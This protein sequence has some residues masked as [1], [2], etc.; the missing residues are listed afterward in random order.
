MG[1]WI[2]HCNLQSDMLYNTM[3]SPNIWSYR[4]SF[5]F[6][7]CNS[8]S[9]GLP[10]LRHISSVHCSPGKEKMDLCIWLLWY[11]GCNYSKYQL[12]DSKWNRNGCAINHVRSHHNLYA[13]S[14]HQSQP[15]LTC[16][17]YENSLFY[18]RWLIFIF[19][20][21]GCY[22]STVYHHMF[23]WAACVA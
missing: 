13:P 1:T 21:Q 15:S 23:N 9:L 4:V 8:E 12:Y 10:E 17:K 20:I 14:I 19:F 18:L 7:C 22:F 3:T 16:N 11:W 6:M 2:V 5:V